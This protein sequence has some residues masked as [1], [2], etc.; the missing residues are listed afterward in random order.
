[1]AI[2]TREDPP[3]PLARLRSQNELLEIRTNDLRFEA[4]ESSQFFNDLL[5]IQLQP[6]IVQ[7]L[8]DRTEG[9][10]AGLQL[11]GLSLQG[12]LQADLLIQ[13]LTAGT[14]FMLNYLA[15]EVLNK[16]P[17][18]IQDFL[19]KTSLLSTLSAERCNLLTDRQ[20][21]AE[22]LDRLEKSNLFI[23]PLDEQ[24]HYYRYHALFAELL[25]NRLNRQGEEQVR[26]LHRRAAQA[27]LAEGL[28]IESL[29]HYL[30][31]KDYPAVL[32]LI[33]KKH[34]ALCQPHPGC[35]N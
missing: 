24:F 15:E 5:N 30:A 18:D 34:L 20:D 6:S 11:A 7:A 19:L 32:D 27:L 33:E 10:A 12:S 8:T 31:A 2:L 17:P 25:R 22:I 4:Q 35:P 9:W 23:Q 3:L 1:M 21:S 28:V 14:R 16:Q 13:D 29:S 26:S